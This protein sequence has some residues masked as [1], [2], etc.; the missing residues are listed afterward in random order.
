MDDF[1]ALVETAIRTY[2]VVQVVFTALGALYKVGLFQLPGAGASLVS[3]STGNFF[4]RYCHW[5]FLLL[6]AGFR[7]RHVF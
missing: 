2:T 1:F 3:T 4:L 5:S 6:D 7:P